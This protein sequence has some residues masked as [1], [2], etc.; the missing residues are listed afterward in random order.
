MFLLS[1]PDDSRFISARI[2]VKKNLV[3]MLHFLQYNDGPRVHLSFRV[4]IARP[5]LKLVSVCY[6]S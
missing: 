1:T 6:A 4:F 2:Q 3:E 5:V